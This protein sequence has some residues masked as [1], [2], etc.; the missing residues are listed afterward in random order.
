MPR[1]TLPLCGGMDMS[2]DAIIT[3]MLY[4][5]GAVYLLVNDSIITNEE[6]EVYSRGALIKYDIASGS[7]VKV[8]WMDGK[9]TKD[10]KTGARKGQYGDILYESYGN[11]HNKETGILYVFDYANNGSGSAYNF[12]APYNNVNSV[13]SGPQKFIAL[14]PKKL[15]IADSGIAFY[16]DNDGV[17]KYKEVNRVIYVDLDKLSVTD[18]ENITATEFNYQ[19]PSPGVTDFYSTNTSVDISSLYRWNTS[20]GGAIV[21]FDT[22]YA[23]LYGSFI[24]DE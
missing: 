19:Y 16:T 6:G 18:S 13:F 24:K 17:L 20:D 5:D 22:S 4:Q 2:A 14:K 10:I 12:Y 11:E 23:Q 7:I 8:G 21:H 1:K 9:T 3:D 15:V